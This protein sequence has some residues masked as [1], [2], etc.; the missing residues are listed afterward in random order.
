[1]RAIQQCT[2]E[3]LHNKTVSVRVD[4]NVPCHNGHITDFTRIDRSYQTIA[5]LLKHK[6]RVIVLAHLGR[7]KHAKERYKDTHDATVYIPE[8]EF[9]FASLLPT[10]EKHL[11]TSLTLCA[12]INDCAH[13]TSP[14]IVCDNIRFYGGEESNDPTFA[15]LLS[16]HA[17]MYVND[18]FSCAHRAHASTEGIAH[19]LPT[20]GGFDLHTEVTSLTRLLQ[21]PKKP[22]WGIVGGSKVS[23]KIDLLTHLSKTLDGLIIGGAMANTFLKARGVPVG[24][25]LVEDD[26]CPL[27]EKIIKE[28]TAE[29]V[30]PLDA[31]CADTFSSQTSTIY[32]YGSIPPHAAAFDIGPE[33]K[34]LFKN[35]IQG[36][37]TLLWNGPVGVFENVTFAHGTTF[38]AKLLSDQTHTGVLTIAG[39]GDTLSA[40]HQ[41]HVQFPLTYTSTAGGAFLEW[42]EGKQLPGL[43]I[44]P[45]P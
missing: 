40:L 11:Q 1:M 42:L 44:I 8:P 4:W 2:P 33:T 19:Y 39:G 41:A 5:Y 37:A 35:K 6:A 45:N 28:A 3:I 7:P 27:A 9:S 31:R 15:H 24:A 20:Y 26:L 30:L 22:V 32:R 36:A 34:Q 16:T 18:A 21:T 14:L 29:I 25:S 38:I 43:A 10:I 23:T 12:H 17:D 13:T